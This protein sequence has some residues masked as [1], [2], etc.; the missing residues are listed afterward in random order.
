RHEPS[1][2]AL[3]HVAWVGSAAHVWTWPAPT[4]ETGADE[5][6]WIPESLLRP[7]VQGDGLRLLR[8]VDGY[9]GQYWLD[10]GLRASQW[11]P[12]PPDDAGWRRFARSCG[13]APSLVPPVPEPEAAPWGEP[14]GD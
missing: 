6:D 13:L 4:L 3:F 2:A 5:G 10:G 9:E 1:P 14:W 11:W 8:L 12:R 7:P